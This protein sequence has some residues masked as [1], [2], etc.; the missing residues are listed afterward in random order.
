MARPVLRQPSPRR[1]ASRRTYSRRPGVRPAI[2]SVSQKMRAV[3]L[4]KQQALTINNTLSKKSSKSILPRLTLKIW[5]LIVS[6]VFMGVMLFGCMVITLWIGSIYGNGILPGVS[7][8]GNNLGGMTQDEAAITLQSQWTAITLQ[9]GQRAWSA[10]PDSLGIYLD[11]NATVE[12][13][14]QQGRGEGGLFTTLAGVEIEPVVLVD[15]ENMRNAL[16]SMSDQMKIDPIDAGVEFINGQVRA[17]EPVN[18]R[19]LDVELTIQGIINNGAR[20]LTD[21]VIDL[22][23][24]SVQP[25]ITDASPMVAA[26]SQLLTNPLTIQAFD[27]VTGDIAEWRLPPESWAMWLTA[28]ADA[29]NP[30]GLTLDVQDGAV[31]DFLNVQSNIFDETRYL[32]MD[33]AVETIKQAIM[34]RNMN[35]VIRVYHHDRQHT[36]QYGDSITSVAWDY[37]V[38]YPWIQQSNPGVGALSVGQIIIIPSADNFLEFPVIHNKRVVVSISLQHTWVYENGTLKWDW[39]SSTG[40]QDSPTWP[41]IYQII[42][43]EQS[44]YAQNWDLYMPYFM[45]VYRPIPG[46]DFTNGFHGFP[47]RGGGQLLWENSLGRK[48]TYGCI[49]LSNTNANLL[50]DWAE[51]GVVVEIQK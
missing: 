48:V 42:S 20:E 38:P 47:T 41:G 12:T 45:G 9:D 18:G 50:Y 15:A 23:M 37:G 25:V 39:S 32:N 28:T 6:L 5:L 11:V 40:I 21:G 44:A 51:E 13:A 30:T 35:P 17:T 16:V 31:R 24:V 29:S 2:L 36:V 8:A 7:V 27:P 19:I 43:H 4:S 10:N 49:L 33:E 1:P 14:Y 46:S 3:H 34:T 22:T 26:A